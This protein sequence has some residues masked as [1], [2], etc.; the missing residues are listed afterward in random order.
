VGKTKAVHN[1]DTSGNAAPDTDSQV[2]EAW[3]TKGSTTTSAG[4]LSISALTLQYKKGHLI[5]TVDATLKLG[6]L[7][8]SVIGF[9]LDITLSGVKLDHLADIVTHGLISASLPGMEVGVQQGPLTLNG[10][11]I[12]DK[13]SSSCTSTSP[14]RWART[15]WSGVRTISGAAHKCTSGSSASTSASAQTR[16]PA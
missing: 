3:P 12:H 15:L 5:V 16:T 10:V 2:S 11:F 8:F 6:Q 9:A 4:S 7:T 13:T 1:T 14:S